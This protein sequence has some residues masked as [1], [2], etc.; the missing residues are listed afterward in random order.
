MINNSILTLEDVKEQLIREMED[1]RITDADII[2]A[3][4]DFYS[5]VQR[6]D[7]NHAPEKYEV[8]SSAITLTS[9]GYDLSN[10]TNI[11]TLEGLKVYLGLRTTTNM[12]PKRFKGSLQTGYYLVGS[13]L[14]WTPLMSDTA[15]RTIYIDYVTKTT[16][17]ATTASLADHTIEIDQDLERALRKYLRHSFFDG[18]YQ[19]DLRND[20]ED[21]AFQELQRYFDSNLSNRGW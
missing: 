8:E 12:I 19:F 9:S 15:S 13:T 1:T 6:A 21:K 14:F 18:H 11:G 3:M 20:A 5:I 16:R 4:N 7:R 17:I 10:L 2:D